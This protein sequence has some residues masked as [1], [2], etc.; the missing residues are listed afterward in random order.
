MSRGA[1]NFQRERVL[2]CA[3]F[4]RDAALIQRELIAAG[5]AAEI[6]DTIEAL[7]SAIKEGAG[8]ALVA[9]EALLPQAVKRLAE[10]LESQPPWSDFPLLVMTSGGG[11]T[12]ESRYRLRLLGPLGNV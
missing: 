2:I 6:F 7:S 4:G 12:D 8:A 3:P 11:T 5:L 10:E 9:D 1:E